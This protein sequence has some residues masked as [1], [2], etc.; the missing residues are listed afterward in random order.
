MATAS[1]GV[2]GVD[3][4]GHL[5]ANDGHGK[6]R[7]AAIGAAHPPFGHR[8][9]RGGSLSPRGLRDRAPQWF[10]G[11]QHFVPPAR[12]SRST[13]ISVR[14]T[15]GMNHRVRGRG[16]RPAAAGW[17]GFRN[18]PRRLADPPPRS[19][20][21]RIHA[22]LKGTGQED[23]SLGA[24]RDHAPRPRWTCSRITFRD[25]MKECYWYS[26]F[27]KPS[28]SSRFRIRRRFPHGRLQ[29]DGSVPAFSSRRR[30]DARPAA[31]PAA[32]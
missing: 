21:G 2:S 17:P 6:H 25:E 32:P 19:P 13:T 12:R 26:R 27:T 4:S 20:I 23:F 10:A 16:W 30:T 8:H 5:P 14:P 31:R 24:A 7:A 9:P 22:P 18:R 3:D 11:L 1:Q 29:R 28:T 15:R